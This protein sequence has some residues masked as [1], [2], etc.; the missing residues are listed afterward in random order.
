MKQKMDL[1]ELA[2]RINVAGKQIAEG[3]EAFAR[4]IAQAVDRVPVELPGTSFKEWAVKHL[5]KPN[6]EPYAYNTLVR[7]AMF[8][9]NPGMLEAHQE[10]INDIERRRRAV[11]NPVSPD[12]Q[13]RLLELAWAKANG[14]VRLRFLSVIVRQFPWI[15]EVLLGKGRAKA[16]RV[17]VD[18]V[19][20]EQ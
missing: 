18:E 11:L 3:R 16:R 20:A 8:G 6:G 15:K 13:L 1:R 2:T 5:H 12:E 14:E 19:W 10:Q 7:Y 17:K 9:R 4:Y